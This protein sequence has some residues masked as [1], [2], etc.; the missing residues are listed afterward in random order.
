[1]GVNPG[2]QQI[3]E[4]YDTADEIQRVG[5]RHA[6]PAQAGVDFDVN[7]G[8]PARSAGDRLGTGDIVYR[9]RQTVLE[10]NWHAFGE[11][12]AKHQDRQIDAGVANRQGVFQAA[13]RE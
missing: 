5:Q 3:I 6:Q 9:R 4:R 12:T 8:R 10:Q 11:R 7:P 1:M 2:D 13:C